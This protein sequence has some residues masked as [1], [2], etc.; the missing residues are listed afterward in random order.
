MAEFKLGRIRFIWKGTWSDGTS[1]VRDDIVAYGGKTFICIL[2]H[3]ASA[4]LETDLTDIQPKWEQFGDGLAWRGGWQV[5]TYY[6][7][8]DIVSNGGFLYICNNGHTSNADILLGLEANISDW[9]LFAE[10]ISYAGNWGTNTKYKINDIVKYGASTYICSTA[11]TSA[12]TAEL[13]LED[14]LGD[15]QLFSE[16]F[17]WKSIWAVS[18]RYKPND[19]VNYYGHLYVCS[20]G[21]TSQALEADGLEADSNNWQSFY[22]GINYRQEWTPATRY[23]V[24]DIVKNGPGLWI[25]TAPHTATAVFASDESN[26]EVFLPGLEFEDSWN[27][28][29]TYQIGDI[30][31]YGGFTY[32][33]KTNHSGSTPSTT[34]ADWDLFITGFRLIGDWD[35][36]TNYRIGDVVRLNGYSYLANADNLNQQPPNTSYWD[37]LNEGLFWKNAWADAT[38]YVLGDVVSYNN[39]AYIVV[40]AHTS[41]AASNRPDLDLTGTFW[42]IVSATAEETALTADGDILYYSGAGPARLPI[43]EPG[44]ILAVNSAGTAPEWKNFGL[45]DNVYYVSKNGTDADGYGTTLDRP[46]ATVKY[47]CDTI[48]NATTR[49]NAKYLLDQNYDFIADETV[50]WVDYQVTNEIAPFT[51]A[52]TYDKAKCRR[53]IKLITRSLAYD[54]SHGGNVEARKMA[55]SY[56]TD[57]GLSYISGQTSETVAAI[58]YHLEVVDAVLSNVA[59][60]VNYQTQNGV[61]DPSTQTIDGSYTEEVDAESTYDSL[62]SLI[63]TAIT[64]GNLTSLPAEQTVH[65][66]VFIKTGEF[67]EQLPI[68]VPSHTALVGDELRSTRIK[69]AASFETADMF[70]VRNGCGLRNMTLRDLSGSLGAPN[71]YGTSRPSAGAYVSLDPGEG[72]DDSLAW[73]HN[74]SPYIQNVTTFG[75]GCVGLKVDGDLHD[76]G[77]DSIVANDFTQIL[78]DGIGYWV[79]DLG[80]SELVS[81]FTYYCHIGYLSENGGKIRATN[82]NN[83]YGTFG[84]V[85]EGIDSTEVPNTGAVNNFYSEAIVYNTFTDG[86][87]ILALEFANSGINYTTADYTII[88]E[89]V[90]ASVASSNIRTNGVFEVRL[91]NTNDEFGGD[92]YTSAFNT[93]QSGSSTSITISA[94]DLANSA[95]YVGMAIYIEDGLGVGQYGYIDTFNAGTKIASIK[96][97][98]DDTA[99]WDHLVPGT[100]VEA[101]LDQTT[102]YRIEP[103]ITFADPVSG[104]TARGR[105]RIASE[106]L[107]QITIFEPGS[108]YDPLNPPTVTI[109]DP[110]NTVDAP[111]EV[112]VGSGTLAQPTWTDRGAGYETATVSIDGDGFADIKQNGKFVYVD[113]LL[114]EPLP[115]SNLQIAGDSNIYKLVQVFELD[116]AGPYSARLQVSP[117]IPVDQEPADGAAVTLRI[118]YSQVRLTGHDFLDIGTGNFADTNYPGIPVNNPNPNNE[119]VE[120]GGGRVF[121]TSTDQ[122]GNFRVG[123][124]FTV[125]QATGTATLDADNF[126]VS[127]LQ[128]LQLG[129]VSLGGTSATI[130]EF[131][132]DGTFA[133]DSDNIVPTQRAIRTYINAQIGGGSATLNVNTL[134]SGNIQIT[135]NTISTT[136]GSAIT[137]G[138]TTDFTQGVSG[139]PLALQYFLNA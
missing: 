109:T 98:S 118:R 119:T 15:W 58:N 110:T 125:E 99:G 40:Q 106:K 83:S 131:S 81:V 11:H 14:N 100:A 76:G 63:T 64:D 62:A 72:T 120:G 2:A 137:V 50:E 25:C 93:A 55:K 86:D 70:R 61:A 82:G 129:S 3:T 115:G 87:R 12:A 17:D 44:Q 19:I 49:A 30:V 101:T 133:A 23:T 69:P 117:E 10:G 71:S 80:R 111:L 90:G 16:G 95:D 105:I 112:R 33:S 52:F 36:T 28:S 56:F 66:T 57:A 7:V 114:E 77:N 6:K 75:T 126:S 68:V 9:D 96:K 45:I 92:G 108:G 85:A 79:T 8:N 34:P 31:T 37:K 46:Y 13:G 38:A 104:I 135:G 130:R 128:E 42:N 123:D 127:G 29:T 122:D 53:D 18:T 124:L 107:F 116:G 5:A 43:G 41:D 4:D 67:E 27:N 65:N 74:K 84:S 97:M 121:Y 139:T 35:T 88:G 22:D 103:R 89:G 94:T 21:H 73:I 113:G 60:A 32:V 54:I 51:S 91:L 39:N 102:Q 48:L 132:T 138:A 26:W 136:D 24:N 20:I 1:Y 134:V 59:P 47:A 78:S